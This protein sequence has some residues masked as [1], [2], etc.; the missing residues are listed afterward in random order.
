MR[1]EYVYQVHDEFGCLRV[2]YSLVEAQRFAGYDH[3]IVKVKAERAP[4][5]RFDM[6]DFEPAPF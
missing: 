1:N 2:F 3:K 4:R 6:M 5:E